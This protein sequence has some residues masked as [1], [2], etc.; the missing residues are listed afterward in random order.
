MVKF[1]SS[2]RQT[3]NHLVSEMVTQLG[4]DTR[5]LMLRIGLHCGPV[6]A[7]VL[8]GQKSRFQL[9]GDT[10]NTASR[11]ESNGVPN[12]I[13][14]SPEIAKVLDESGKG[15]WITPRDTLV[16]AKGKGAIQTYWVE[17]AG[18]GSTSGTS[19]AN[20]NCLDETALIDWTTDLLCFLTK[21]AKG[22]Y[23]SC[24][25]AQPRVE[26]DFKDFGTLL[27]EVEEVIEIPPYNP[28]QKHSPHGVSELS[29][30]EK[31]EIQAF[32][33][34]ISRTYRSKC[35]SGRCTYE[36]P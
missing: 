25:I 13:H 10:V 4:P 6:T 36:S 35:T 33:T 9:F 8:R 12:K 23:Q 32:V 26:V 19:H 15:H 3:F 31:K 22:H 11:M 2:C 34:A 30:L 1:A 29:D 17:P 28:E 27:E 24:D 14:I 16:Q 20:S 7:G 21:Q 5:D 18:K